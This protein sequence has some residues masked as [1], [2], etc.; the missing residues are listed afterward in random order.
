MSISKAYI[1]KSSSKNM[2]QNSL[3]LDLGGEKLAI[4]GA[5]N[6]QDAEQLA[7]ILD[8]NS[9]PVIDLSSEFKSKS[10][11]YKVD[12]TLRNYYNLDSD[13]F[14]DS[15]LDSCFSLEHIVMATRKTVTFAKKLKTAIC[16]CLMDKYGHEIFSYRMPETLLISIEL[17]KKKAISAIFMKMPTEKIQA[18][19]QP[20]E[21]LYQ[22]EAI[23]QGQIVSFG[24]GLPIYHLEKLIGSIGVSGAQD[25]TDDARIA[26]CFVHYFTQCCQ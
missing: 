12:S 1:F 13:T 6:L 24:G 16:I 10:A 20:G 23:S 22:L 17:A 26:N 9:V 7:S 11:Q 2:L 15:I 18:L 3:K 21:P 19:T 4:F 8:S 5:K 25:P 14:M